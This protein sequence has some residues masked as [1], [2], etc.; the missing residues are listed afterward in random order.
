[1]LTQQEIRNIHV[2][3]LP[4]GLK[5]RPYPKAVLPSL[6]SFILWDFFFL[7]HWDFLVSPC[8]VTLFKKLKKL[9]SPS[10]PFGLHKP[11]RAQE[12]LDLDPEASG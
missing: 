6:C 8:F 2:S 7:I 10:H 5:A 12:K 9:L 1:M 3:T 11:A 4:W